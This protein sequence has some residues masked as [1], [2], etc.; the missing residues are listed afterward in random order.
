MNELPIPRIEL[1]VE[2]RT[3]IIDKLAEMLVV[4]FRTTHDL[5]VPNWTDNSTR[6]D[7]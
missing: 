5:T 7:V 3:F 4:D 2:D 1:S 6:G